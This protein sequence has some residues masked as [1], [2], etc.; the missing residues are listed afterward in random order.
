MSGSTSA[1]D[2]GFST[3][4][5]ETRSGKYKS[6]SLYV[7]LEPD[8]INGVKTGPYQSLFHPENMISGKESAAS[9]WLPA[10]LLS[11]WRGTG[12]GFGA[13]L[14]ERLFADYDKKFKFEFC[15]YA[16][17][18]LSTSI[19]EPY[20]SV[21]TTHRTLEHSDCSFLVDNQAIYDI[22]KKN[23]LVAFPSF[24]NLNR[25]TAHAISCITASL[26]F[27]ATL[28]VDLNEVQTN[29]VL[30]P[31]IHFPLA[32]L[33][34]L[35]S[36]ETAL[37][38]T[39]YVPEMIYSDFESGNQMVKCDPPEGKCMACLMLFR[40]DFAPK[41]ASA[42]VAVIKTKR[43]IQFVDWCPSGIKSGG[44]NERPS[45]F[46]G[47]DL[48]RMTSNVCMMS[49]TTAISAAWSRLDRKF[50]LLY[51]K[52]AFV[53]W[54]VREGMEFC[55]TGYSQY[56]LAKL[57][58]KLVMHAGSS[59]PSSTGWVYGNCFNGV[60][61]LHD[62]I[63]AECKRIYT[64]HPSERSFPRPGQESTF[65]VP[66][67]SGVI[68]DAKTGPYQ[69]LF[70]PKN[71]ITNKKDA[72]NNF[73]STHFMAFILNESMTASDTDTRGCYTIDKEL[74]DPALDQI[75][76]L[77]DNCSAL[78]SFFIFR[79]LGGGIGSGFGALLLERLS[80]DYDKKYKYEFCVYL[81][82]QLR[83]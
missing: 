24:V 72:A 66:S 37:H 33:A 57:V 46:P 6:R 13:L 40:G 3:F 10:V 42:A 11:R 55:G 52:R 31:R 53:H 80:A 63:P 74:I 59:T 62:A 69:S 81:L 30:F 71:M 26:R 58:F 68:D 27:D 15:V 83:P 76:R 51:S 7:D 60:L 56:T 8:V 23:L 65:S 1:S 22:C 54:Y 16:A 43:T 36:A 20:N 64:A 50:D 41:D 19:V 77:G 28:N 17:P 73:R 47:G 79:S 38:E 75:R 78:E 34:P 25:L 44:C 70:R 14:L 39:N 29:L 5:S 67:R 61:Y 82:V 45:F 35:R 48:A 21:L 2:D 12:S 9:N 4:F 49:N 18:Q 32:T